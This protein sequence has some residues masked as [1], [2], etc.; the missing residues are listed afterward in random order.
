MK[1]LITAVTLTLTLMLA[2]AGIVLAEDI[3]I[4]HAKPGDVT[5]QHKM[6]QE[7]LKDCKICHE[8]EPG[9]IE[10]GFSKDF[11]HKTCKGCHTEKGKGPTKC[12]E[13]HKK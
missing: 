7:M 10:G 3:I 9:K 1:K 5:F 2:S 12:T 11:A 6:H 8:K 4:F 13:C